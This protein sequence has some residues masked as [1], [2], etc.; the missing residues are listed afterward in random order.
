MYLNR[1]SISYGIS[2]G[3]VTVT[4]CGDI[5]GSICAIHIGIAPTFCME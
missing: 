2:K 5:G 4:L 3:I 1:I